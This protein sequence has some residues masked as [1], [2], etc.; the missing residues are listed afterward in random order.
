MDKFIMHLNTFAEQY[1]DV[2]QLENYVQL[3]VTKATK[4]MKKESLLEKMQ[5][6][7]DGTI[8]MQISEEARKLVTFIIKRKAIHIF[9][10]PN[11]E[12]EY[13]G[14]QNLL[15][16]IIDMA[17]PHDYCDLRKYE[18]ENNRSLFKFVVG[19]DARFYCE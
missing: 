1:V 2:D 12:G 6:L 15:Q 11:E 19:Q 10:A 4:Q 17:A 13:T 14:S 5:K 8:Q 9:T 7:T 18:R 16:D 3:I